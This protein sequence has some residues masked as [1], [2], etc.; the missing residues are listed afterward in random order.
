MEQVTRAVRCEMARTVE[1]VLAR[2]TRVLFL[3]ARRA[4]DLARPVAEVMAAELGRDGIWVEG[5]VD[6]F[7]KLAEG[8][9]PQ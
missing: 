4:V 1:D 5:Q 8:Y 3:D 2:R 6:D 7:T 9:V